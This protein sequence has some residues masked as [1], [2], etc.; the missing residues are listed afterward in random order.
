MSRRDDVSEED[1]AVDQHQRTVLKGKAHPSF[2][3]PWLDICHLFL[4][5]SSQSLTLVSHH[6]RSASS[7]DPP[8]V[9]P[10]SHPLFQPS[11]SSSS[12]STLQPPAH[13]TASLH[14]S[15]DNDEDSYMLVARV[16]DDGQSLELSVLSVTPQGASLDFPQSSGATPRLFTFP[17]PILPDVALVSDE[18]SHTIYVVAVTVTGWLYRLRFPLPGAFFNST[19]PHNW[20]VEHRITS[21]CGHTDQEAQSIGGAKTPTLVH[22]VQPG[23]VIVACRDGSMVKLE[24]QRTDHQYQ[25]LSLEAHV[26]V[27]A[28]LRSY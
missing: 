9:I 16:L 7:R 1:Q 18:D 5:M 15:D 20:A 26:P 27:H 8:I 3:S 14:T 2:L 25:G 10:T 6:L 24:Q 17:A 11:G 13:A 23:V 22:V 4:V 19:L 12:S 21:I 28:P